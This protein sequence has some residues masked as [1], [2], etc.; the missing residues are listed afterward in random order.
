MLLFFKKN[1]TLSFVDKLLFFA[2][3]CRN[4]LISIYYSICIINHFFDLSL[5]AQFRVSVLEA[6][7]EDVS[8]V[9]HVEQ[10]ERN[11]DQGVENGHNLP[12]VSLWS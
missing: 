7:P 4:N 9:A 6:G 2:T 8:N 12:D 11:P 1:V 10:H 5:P 3:L